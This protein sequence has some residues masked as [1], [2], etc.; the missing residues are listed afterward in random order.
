L[1]V[2]DP[3]AEMRV[4][5]IDVAPGI[6]DANDRLAGPVDGIVAELAQPG[7]VAEGAQIGDAEPA[8]AA[9]SLGILIGHAPSSLVLCLPAAARRPRTYERAHSR[10]ASPSRRAPSSDPARRWPRQ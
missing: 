2:L 6:D 5:G 10:C 3:L 7:A 9:Q 4:A 8:V 1:D